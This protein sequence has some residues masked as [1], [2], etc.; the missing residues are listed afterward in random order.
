MP[1][2]T[3]ITADP[4]LSIKNPDNTVTIIRKPYLFVS[5]LSVVRRFELNPNPSYLD[6]L[7]YATGGKG[8]SS[9]TG[10]GSRA[11][12]NISAMGVNVE[13]GNL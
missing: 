4:G 11:F 10:D 1:A 12:Q 6:T 7:P 13:S 8:L 2:P 9:G 3:F 5:D